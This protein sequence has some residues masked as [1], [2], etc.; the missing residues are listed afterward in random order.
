M[1]LE[2]DRWKLE[3]VEVEDA[4]ELFW[5]STNS[6]SSSP[7]FYSFNRSVSQLRT[8]RVL[9]DN[10]QNPVDL[11]EQALQA[12]L[13]QLK[14][15]CQEK[16]YGENKRALKHYLKF[17]LPSP[18]RQQLLNLSLKDHRIYTLVDVMY[19]L[20]IDEYSYEG[21]DAPCAFQITF[22]HLSACVLIADI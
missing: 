19:L 5:P 15:L 8:S 9:S 6:S 12:Y 10:K 14:N 11:K 3:A 17:Q 1:K 2:S 7:R 21:L 4:E 16:N 18:L 20:L 22:V 13:V